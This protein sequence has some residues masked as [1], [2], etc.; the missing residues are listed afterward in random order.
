M[1]QKIK[2]Q[3]AHHHQA[4]IDVDRMH[5]FTKKQ[6]Q[7]VNTHYLPIRIKTGSRRLRSVLFTPNLHYWLTFSLFLNIYN[8]SFLIP[9]YF[10]LIDKSG[11][12]LEW[13]MRQPGE[14][15]A[16]RQDSSYVKL[17]SES[18]VVSGDSPCFGPPDVVITCSL[19]FAF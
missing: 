1:V 3:Q 14:S 7:K 6:R 5:T 19:L 16:W 8:R 17:R 4:L 13:N 18:D 2:H 12:Y 10:Q 11:T 15:A 9:T